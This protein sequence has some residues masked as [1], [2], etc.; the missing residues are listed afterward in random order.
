MRRLRLKGLHAEFDYRVS[1]LEDHYLGDRLMQIGLPIL[2]LDGDYKS[3]WFK[4]SAAN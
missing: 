4:L 3:V 1:G 2:P